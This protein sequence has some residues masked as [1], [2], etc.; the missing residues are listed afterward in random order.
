MTAEVV[1]AAEA[2]SKR[3]NGLEALAE[4]SFA[5]YAGET[6]ALIGPNGA[7]KTTCFK[8]LSGEMAP[9]SGK[10]H[11][12]GRDVTRKSMAERVRAGMGRSFQVPGVFASMTAGEAAALALAAAGGKPCRMWGRLEVPEA[13]LALLERVGL[14]GAAETPCGRLAHGDRKR[15]DLA[16]ALARGPRLLLMDEPGAGMAPGE[17]RALAALLRAERARSGIALLF[18]EHDME[19]VFGLADQILVLDRGRLIAEGSPA[20]IRADP[21]VR[22]VYLGEEAGVGAGFQ[23]KP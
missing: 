16:L 22:A 1:L 5:L 3:F 14:G 2:L 17:R 23:P 7:G 11:L 20:A 18:T 9:D 15:L 13:A 10:V 6:L 4:V 19:A 8:L 12:F 21:R